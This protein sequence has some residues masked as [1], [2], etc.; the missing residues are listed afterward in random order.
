[1]IYQPGRFDVEVTTD[2]TDAGSV[3]ELAVGEQKLR[4]AVGASGG[5]ETRPRPRLSGRSVSIEPDP[6]F[7]P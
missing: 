5:F 2:Q 4:G 7:C 3:Y 1:M 6:L